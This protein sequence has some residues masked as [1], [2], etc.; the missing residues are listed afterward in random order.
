MSYESL[1]ANQ[2]TTN[3]LSSRPANRLI[4]EVTGKVAQLFRRTRLISHYRQ[5]RATFKK[6]NL[7]EY[8]GE[9]LSSE[10]MKY[11]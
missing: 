1:W 4:M 3:E 6:M 2:N 8:Y 11:L 9:I 5:Q 7:S 10:W